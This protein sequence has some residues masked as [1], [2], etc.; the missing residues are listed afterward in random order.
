MSVW[1]QIE[2]DLSQYSGRPYRI[3]QKQGIGG[4]SINHAFR[5]SDGEQQFFVKTNHQHLAHMFEAEA[6]GMRWLRETG[7]ARVA[8]V[9]ADVV[10]TVAFTVTAITAAA[11]TAIRGRVKNRL[12]G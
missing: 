6:R 12:L 3:R 11:A 7:G 2:Q 4:G 5:I 1:Q 8:T 9:L 10:G